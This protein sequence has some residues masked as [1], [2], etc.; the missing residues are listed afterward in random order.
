MTTQDIQIYASLII[1][2]LTA[3]VGWMAN[4]YHTTGKAQASAATA[5]TAHTTAQTATTQA[6]QMRSLA[7]TLVKAAGQ[8]M[9]DNSAKYAWV[10]QQLLATYPVLGAPATK[11]L[12]EAAVAEWKVM[13]PVVLHAATTLIEPAPPAPDGAIHPPVETAPGA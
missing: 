11:A 10:E 4:T 12:I 2:L 13:Q 6:D 9:T 7:L 8:W 3:F 5:Q 1:A